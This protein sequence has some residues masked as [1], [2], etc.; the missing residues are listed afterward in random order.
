MLWSSMQSAT[1]ALIS[2]L[3]FSMFL[4]CMLERWRKE[5]LLDH[6]DDN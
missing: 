6:K 2:A 3:V 5:P 1:T 4:K